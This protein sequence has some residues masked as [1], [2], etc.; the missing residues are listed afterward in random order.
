MEKEDILK[1]LGLSDKEAKTYLAVLQLGSSTIKPI[2]DKAGIKRTSVYNFID[3][4]VNTGLISQTKIRS[5]MHYSAQPPARLLELQKESLS[6]VENALP[7]FSALFNTSRK[8]V[9]V[10][11]FDGPGQMQKIVWE[12]ARCIKET[13]YIWT[14]RDVLEMIGGPKFMMEVDRQR[15]QNG[16]FIKTIRFREKEAPYPYSSAGTKYLRQLRYAPKGIDIP[17]TMGIY[18]TGKVGFLS[19]KHEGFGILIESQEFMQTMTIFHQLL[20]EKS[21]EGKVGEG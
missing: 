6:A 4:L 13:R 20:W 9:R 19:T 14:G 17:M 2:A 12:E 1:N 5:R 11:Y 18:D 21:T 7:E 15:I 16:I 3:H 10:Q 8:K